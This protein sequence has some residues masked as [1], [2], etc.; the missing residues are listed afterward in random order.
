MTVCLG[1]LCPADGS[2]VVAADRMVTGGR[3]AVEFE[4]E[5]SKIE[6]LAPNCV[7]MAAG[8][9]LG[10]RE[11]FRAVR[12]RIGDRQSLAIAAIADIAK[13]AF[14]EQRLRLAE[15]QY[16]RGRGLTV[17]EFYEHYLDKWPRELVVALDQ[18]I[19]ETTI[20]ID[21]LIAGVDNEP[22]LYLIEGVGVLSCWDSLGFCAIGSGTS[23]A[24]L[25]WIARCSGPADAL[26]RAVYV[27]HEAKFRAEA[28]PGVGCDTDMMV[29]TP[30]GARELPRASVHEMRTHQAGLT[31]QP[32]PGLERIAETLARLVG[33]KEVDANGR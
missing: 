29:V 5:G 8:N 1:I 16:L 7:A 14:V 13:R 12:E 27:A 4:H 22:H 18:E 31:S 20:G 21:V 17:R 3:P 11:L 26:T 23:L 28:H 32:M 2:V 25:Q 6:Q 19:Q 24:T 15:D 30:A 10:T 9:A 33:D